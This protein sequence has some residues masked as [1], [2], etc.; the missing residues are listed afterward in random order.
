GYLQPRPV[1]KK[2]TLMVIDKRRQAC[3]C[4][5]S[6]NKGSRIVQPILNVRCKPYS[7]LGLNANTCGA[8]LRTHHGKLMV[9]FDANCDKR[10]FTGEDIGKTALNPALTEACVLLPA[11]AERLVKL[12][13]GEDLI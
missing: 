5:N 4:H 1:G 8:V 10:I 7:R 11:S 6:P 9:T 12:H 3:R 13:Y 2:G